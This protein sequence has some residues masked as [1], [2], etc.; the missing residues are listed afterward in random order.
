MILIKGITMSDQHLNESVERAINRVLE[1]E[2]RARDAVD[3]CLAEARQAVNGARVR[4]SRILERA[5][6][7]TGLLHQRC[8]QSVSRRLAE[9]AAEAR[10]IPDQAIVAPEMQQRLQAIVRRL[11]E[12]MTSGV[13]E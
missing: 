8:E 2:R 3:L 5:D 7:R 12:E 10:Q 11:A 13:A 1:A 6:K 9:L 4:S